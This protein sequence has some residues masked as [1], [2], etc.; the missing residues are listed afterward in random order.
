MNIWTG[1][2]YKSIMPEVFKDKGKRIAKLDEKTVR[3]IK[4][5][6]RDTSMSL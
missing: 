1:A 6:R 3:Q 2:R 4:L 5:D